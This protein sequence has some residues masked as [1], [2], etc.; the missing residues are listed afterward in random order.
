MTETVSL[1]IAITPNS[2]HRVQ[3]WAARA[4]LMLESF[5][6]VQ[7]RYRVGAVHTRVKPGQVIVAC[8]TEELP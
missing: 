4:E 5:C 2:R 3:W 8:K 1:G 6:A 7:G